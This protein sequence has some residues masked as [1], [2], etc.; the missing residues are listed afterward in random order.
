MLE[1]F[2]W[3]Q[4]PL[5]LADLSDVVKKHWCYKINPDQNVLQPLVAVTLRAQFIS[6]SFQ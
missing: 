5:V 3:C 4:P 1:L 2:A 6:E